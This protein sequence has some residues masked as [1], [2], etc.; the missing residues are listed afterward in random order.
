[1]FLRILRRRPPAVIAAYL[2]AALISSW[3]AFDILS[4]FLIRLF[5]ANGYLTVAVSALAG[6]ACVAVI[7]VID[8]MR[9]RRP[10]AAFAAGGIGIM[11]AAD[12]LLAG[13]RF[14]EKHIAVG[15]LLHRAAAQESPN[16]ALP[17]R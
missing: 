2:S 11:L 16:L 12:F 1:L 14:S 13:G 5:G 7:A 9:E 6:A 3:L 4:A 15:E 10:R 8:V 17:G